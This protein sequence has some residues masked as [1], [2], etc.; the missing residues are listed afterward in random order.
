MLKECG[1]REGGGRSNTKGSLRTEL[2]CPILSEC[3]VARSGKRLSVWHCGKRG[4][5]EMQN[6]HTS[7]NQV[8]PLGPEE[9]GIRIKGERF[10]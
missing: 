9:P 7:T 5:H 4:R 3:Q 10:V 1:L 6:P 8:H 2:F